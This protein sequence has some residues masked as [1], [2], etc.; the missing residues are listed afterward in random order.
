M[1][2]TFCSSK[3]EKKMT[4][5]IDPKGM[6]GEIS[7]QKKLFTDD[8]HPLH[9]FVLKTNRFPNV[10]TS[11]IAHSYRIC[12]LHVSLYVYMMWTYQSVERDWKL[13]FQNQ[14]P[15]L[16]GHRAIIGSI[17]NVKVHHRNII[18]DLID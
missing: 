14:H 4:A 1:Q 10:Y 13:H 8:V 12:V 11:Q 2:C 6:T 7:Q 15:N 5:I 18:V 16:L 9:Y 3:I 17:L